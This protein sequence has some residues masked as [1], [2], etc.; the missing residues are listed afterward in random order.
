MSKPE[1]NPMPE[2]GENP[3]PEPGEKQPAEVAPVYK[4]T[5]EEI[6]ALKHHWERMAKKKPLPSLKAEMQGDRQAVVFDH[7]DSSIATALLKIGRAHV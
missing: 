7:P 5:E 1:K 6:A 3:V 2:P 4:P